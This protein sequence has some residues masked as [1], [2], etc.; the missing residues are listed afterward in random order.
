[1]IFSHGLGGSRNA[2]SQIAGS[3]ASHGVVVICPEHRDG[4]AIASFVRIPSAQGRF[5][6]RNTR[7]M[8]PFVRIPHNSS[9]EVHELRNDQ[10]RIR[11]WELGLV[12]EAILHIDEGQKL[13]NLDK[14]AAP[15]GQFAGQLHVQEPG[16]IIFSGH[17]FG[18]A[19]VVQFLKSVFYAGRPELEVME[20]SLYTPNWES[21]ICTQV[22]PQ[23]VTIL[24]D[25][26]C[27]PL[28]SNTTKPLFNLPLPAYA[29]S[30]PSF[31]ALESP[32]GRA[33]LAI[34]SED[35]YKWRD[36]LHTT[37]RILSPDPSSLVVAPP[38]NNMSTPYL[39]YVKRSVH[40]SQSDFALLFP[41][42]TRKVFKSESPHRALRLNLRALL[43]ILRVNGIPVAGTQQVDLVDDAAVSSRGSKTS[44]PTPGSRGGGET[45]SV[46]TKGEPCTDDV[47]ILEREG[48]AIRKNKEKETKKKKEKETVA[49]ID[50]LVRAWRWIDI[51]GMGDSSVDDN[52]NDHDE[53]ET[54]KGRKRRGEQEEEGEKTKKEAVIRA[55]EE[56]EPAMASIIEPSAS[57]SDDWPLD[58]AT[59]GVFAPTPRD[60]AS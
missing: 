13:T 43:Q 7:R 45:A 9:D 18:A 48:N 39:F 37:A 17:S 51:V 47:V 35:F 33:I 56:E 11:L 34:E 22:T 30:N 54:R 28:V 58:P 55:T 1:M 10:L 14:N 2:Y 49:D 26:W 32:G 57:V 41:W 31:S 12:H 44:T 24:L 5:F 36:H 40:F 60:V 46:R 8:V 3:M 52:D 38:M 59:A 29:P 19:T 27:F 6:A 53:I 50:E 23:N 16:S 20:T 15:L 25:M 4:S 42:L 21:S